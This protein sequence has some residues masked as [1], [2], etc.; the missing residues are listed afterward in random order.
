KVV[1]IE[2]ENIE[3]E[4]VDRDGETEAC[5]LPAV[6]NVH[7]ALQQLKARF[8]SLIEG[9]DF[10]VHDERVERQAVESQR[11]FR[12]TGGYL[13]AAAGEQPGVLALANRQCPDTVVLQFK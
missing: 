5:H 2:G 1:T 10:A 3:Q 4:V 12:I 8:P 11:Y 13:S 7:P 9:R 6:I